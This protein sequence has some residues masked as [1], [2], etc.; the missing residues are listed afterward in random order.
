M[1]SATSSEAWDLDTAGAGAI[2]AALQVLATPS[3]L[4]ILARLRRGDCTVVELARA[5]RMERS[6]VSH[7]LRLLRIHGLVSNAR[8]GRSVRYRLCDHH[9]AR[10]LDDAVEHLDHLRVDGDDAG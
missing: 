1:S 3:R 4:L 2:A 6:A 9:V 10:L 7:Q 8:Y 5:V